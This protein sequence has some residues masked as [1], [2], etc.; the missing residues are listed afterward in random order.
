MIAFAKTSAVSPQDRFLELLP[1]IER[2]ARKAFY[3]RQPVELEEFWYR[4]SPTRTSP[5]L[6]SS[7][8][9]SKS[10]PTPRRWRCMPCVMFEVDAAS[11][12]RSTS[13]MCCRRPIAT[14]LSSRCNN[15]IAATASRKML[16]EDRHAG[17]A[18]TAAARLDV[19]KW[20]GTC[21]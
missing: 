19:A 14:S 21:R 1:S 8:S 18:E 6:A 15:S 20:S 4:S 9:A 5:S 10:S 2:Q 12:R 7:N 13:T 17:P 16:V 3:D 11:V